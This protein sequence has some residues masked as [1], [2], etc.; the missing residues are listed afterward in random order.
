MERFSVY[1]G[2]MY[3]LRKKV[4]AIKNKCAKYGCDFHF[5]EVGEEVKEIKHPDLHI[6]IKCKFIICE[7][8]GIA[9]VNG[10]QFISS[11]EH[12]EKGNIFR[13]AV[14]DVEIPERYR[15]SA[16]FCEHCNSL[17][18]R[19]GTFIIRN[20]ETGEFKQVGR[21]CLCDFTNGMSVQFATMVASFRPVFEEAEETPSV[22]HIGW[23]DRLFGTRDFLQFAAETIRHFGYSVASKGGSTELRTSDFFDVANGNTRFWEEKRIREVERLM[24]KV[25][26][27]ANSDGAK[28]MVDDAVAWLDAQEEHN[29]YIHNLKVAVALENVDC[30]RFGLLVSLF[31]TYNRELLEQAKRREGAEAGR[32]SEFIGEVGSRVTVNVS[33]VKCI[34]S[35]DSC[36]GRMVTPVTTYVWKITDNENNVFTWKTQNW[37]DEE[38]PPKTIVGTVKEHKVFREVKQTELTRCKVG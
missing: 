37:F 4:T 1:A 6:T 2:H 9:I 34:T 27:D 30:S 31:P 5:A 38:N 25:G 36:F 24:E 19:N 14:T 32:A 21:N 18:K 10:W 20:T 13:K 23:R 26:F 16:P 35:W 29:D 11:V 3:D 17:R 15:T 33:S 7:A 8:E 28:K 22:G 12:T